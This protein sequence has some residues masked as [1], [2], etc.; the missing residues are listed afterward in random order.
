MKKI[1]LKSLLVLI[2]VLITSLTTQVW[3]IDWI[4]T[5]GTRVY[6]DCTNWD[7]DGATFKV[8]Q[9]KGD[10]SQLG[11][12]WAT[13]IN[14]HYYYFDVDKSDVQGF[15]IC[16]MS[17][18]GKTQ[19]NYTDTQYAK[20]RSQNDHYMLTLG[21]FSDNNMPSWGYG[22]FTMT[23]GYTFYFN[24]SV[25][26]WATPHLRVGRT[27]YS[28]A[29]DMD[30]EEGT[31]YLY[32]TGTANWSGYEAITISDKASYTGA[33]SI[34]G[35]GGGDFL[36]SGTTNHHKASVSTDIYANAT[37]ASGTS[38]G[39]TYYTTSYSTLLPTYSATINT[40]SNGT[41]TVYKYT[42]TS[43]D[44]DKNS[45]TNFESI[46]NG[47]TGLLPTH[48]LKI[49]TSANS[50]YRLLNITV[51]NG[52]KIEDVTGGVTYYITG[53]VEISATF[54]AIHDVTVSYKCGETTIKSNTTESAIGESTAK[55]VTAPDIT[56]YDFANWTLG[57]GVADQG[58]N[59][60]A[61]PI[62]VKTLSSGAYTMTANYTEHLA[63]DWKLIGDNTSN[64][65]FGDNYTYASGKAMSK[66]AGHAT[67][68][69]AYITLD[70]THTGTWGFKVATTNDDSNKWGY[71]Q[72]DGAYITFNRDA[73]GVQKQVYSGNEHELKF[74]PDGLGEYEFRVEYTSNKYVYVTFPTVA[75]VTY[76]KTSGGVI[77]ATYSSTAFD[78]GTKVEEGKTVVF[79]ATPNDGYR[80][81][82]WNSNST[83]TGSELSTETTYN[84]TVESTNDVYAIFAENLCTVTIEANTR[85]RGTITVGGEEF[86]WGNSVA[87]GKT[88]TKALSVTPAEGYYF[89]G[90]V[91]SDDDFKISG[92]A[93]DESNTTPTLSGLG[94][95]ASSTGTLTA[96]FEPLEEIYFY[97]YSN[98]SDWSKDH[99]YVYFNVGWNST[100][101][102]QNAVDFTSCP[103][104][105]MS[106]EYGGDTY[107]GYVPR[108]VTRDSSFPIAVAFS[109]EWMADAES[110][111]PTTTW[112]HFFSGAGVYRTDYDQKLNMYVLNST[113]SGTSNSTVYYNNGYW[114]QR[115]TEGSKG[116]GYYL[117]SPKGTQIAEFKAN[118]DYSSF[119][120][121]TVRLD[122]TSDKTYFIRSEG[123]HYYKT[124]TAEGASKTVKI[125]DYS[126]Y[127][128]DEG[129]SGSASGF[130][131][132]P[133]AEGQYTFQLQQLGQSM[134][135]EVSYPTSPGDYRVK[136]SYTIR[137]KANSADSTVYT[138][139]DVM[140]QTRAQYV[141]KTYS[142]YLS[143]G[144]KGTS[145]IVLEQCTGIN[146]LSKQPEWATCDASGLAPVLD[147]LNKY[148]NNVYQF[149]LQVNKDNNEVLSLPKD[150][151]SLYKGHYYLKTDSTA[152]GWADYTHNAMARNSTTFDKSDS[153][154][155]NYY[156]CHY[157]YTSG[158]NIKC[159]VAN[160]YC[161]QLSDTLKGDG[162]ATLS[163]TEPV[164]NAKTSIRFSYNSATN[165]VKRTYLA[166]ST[167]DSY[168]DIKVST[169][170]KVYDSSNNDLYD[171]PYNGAEYCR[172][173]DTKDWV[174]EKNVK[175]IPGGCGGMTATY[176]GKTQVLVPETN[177]LIGGT[178]ESGNKY[179][180]KLLYDFKTN[181]IMTAWVPSGTIQDAL[182]DLDM[183]WERQADHSATQ[184]TFG[185][186]GSLSNVKVVGAI[187]F[188]YDTVHHNGS[189]THHVY[190]ASGGAGWNATNRRH[191]KY[192]VSFPFDVPVASVFGLAEAQLGR[193][194]VI[195]KYNGEKRAAEGLFYG[196]GDNYWE[197][198]TEDEVMNA[199]EG[200]WVIFDN[201]Y[202]AGYLG[203][204]WDNKGAESSVYL[205]F[206]GTTTIASITNSN[207]SIDYAA[208]PCTVDRPWSNNA[209]KNHLNTDSHWRMLGAPLFHDSYIG[210][211]TD[212]D[213]TNYPLS[214]YYYLDLKND[215]GGNVWNNTAVEVGSTYLKAMSSVLVQWYGTITW[216]TSAGAIAAP[217]R[218]DVEKTNYLAK[219]DISYNGEV[220]DWTYVKLKEDADTAFV[221]CEDMCK[222]YNNGLPQVYTFAGAY[223]VAYNATP[224][225]SQTVPVGLRIRKNGNY[226]FSM[227]ENFSGEVTLI[228]T[229]A[230]TRTNLALDDYE[231]YLEK[232]TIDDRFELEINV[233]KMPTAIDGAE[234]GSG[235]LKDGKAHKFIEN[236]V[237]YILEN[238]RI[239]DA[240]GNRVQ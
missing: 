213:A 119:S 176:N 158:G 76:G 140:K 190:I 40:P 235:S 52:T 234:D 180:V 46:S 232:G 8:N 58:S 162:V 64:S 212:E 192:F 85:S 36:V 131:L 138:Y 173:D 38:D 152:G 47:A 199:N 109:N 21:S 198:M 206:P 77:T 69:N 62:S 25:T 63:T 121:V 102:S 120:E 210:A 16:R 170:D 182:S 186:K 91:L 130:T 132:K 144:S 48:I 113:S 12:V 14:G 79:T 207:Q 80:L 165:Q 94:T 139:S 134:M 106:P 184:L 187:R 33:N 129:T 164:A 28:T 214:S 49:V 10:G 22:P 197:N 174:Y 126:G 194:Y 83:G 220:R 156:Y 44:T 35:K 93:S 153:T 136:H 145:T 104:A 56:Y 29:D 50:G 53:D 23:T 122:N 171:S 193:E 223:D 150:K 61:N 133:S 185:A 72:S 215:A 57:A 205:Y 100:D 224:L 219:L 103:M 1:Y 2:G 73:S 175:V 6:L 222:V 13:K 157:Y 216:K 74:S 112:T 75:T 84:H 60:A 66:K 227:P 42:K 217:R 154:T 65:P 110:A 31:M 99:I 208:I 27:N 218:T 90:W 4:L 231:V 127:L 166:A 108:S 240:R 71:G 209:S 226:T 155:F 203:H 237:M 45:L 238:G 191:L 88:T 118:S 183:V 19:W 151:I 137:N 17:S 188:D 149:D 34:Y 18:D 87:V 37:G 111:Y 204:I 39:V 161:N 225:E 167:N 20:N 51:T 195:Q 221:L 59:L 67:E 43:Y 202:I 15:Q 141:E 95:L 107:M 125:D 148:G 70:I 124:V 30:L 9:K 163:G 147:T 233:N 123:G 114:K 3:A 105:E 78:S 236:G 116:V 196:D 211:K 201:D 41:L 98:S 135:Y 24:N 117:E 97:N 142:M 68:S 179:D 5:S 55:N 178:S 101:V 200:Y 172:F 228:D 168:L 7:H 32:S 239:Y 86:D 11:E 160:D 81:V 189:G 159:V 115:W 26:Q 169:N 181:Y 230:Q 146:E 143:E 82:N 54:E 128:A 177:I 96:K 229:Y 89:A 92:T